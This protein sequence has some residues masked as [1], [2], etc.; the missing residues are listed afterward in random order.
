[1]IDGV[2]ISFDRFSY[3]DNIRFSRLSSRVMNLQL[4]QS[5]I[6]GKTKLSKADEDAIMQA[7]SDVDAVLDEQRT[8]FA[9]TVVALPQEMLVVDAPPVDT[10]DLRDPDSF[11]WLRADAVITLRSLVDMSLR[12]MQTEGKV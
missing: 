1:M 2:E 8:I 12:N 6:A 3:G 10:L 4:I 7:M 9:K 5:R 11:L